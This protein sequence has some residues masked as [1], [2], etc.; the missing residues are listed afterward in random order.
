MALEKRLEAVSPQ[1]L[2]SD[3]TTSGRVSV[4]D[5]SLFKVKQQIILNSSSQ[6]STH[7]EVKRILDINTMILGPKSTNIKEYT[8]LSDFTVA[9]GAYIIANEQLRPSIPYEEYSR[10]TYDE[11]PTVANRSV[12]VDKMGDYYEV[13]NPLP[14]QLSDGSINIGVVEA[15][16]EVQ[17]THLDDW[18]E[19]GRIHDSTRIGDGED[20]LQ[21]SEFGEAYVTQGYSSLLPMLSAIPWVQRSNYDEV[22]PTFNG[23]EVTLSYRERGTEIGQAVLTF[24]LQTGIWN[25][26]SESYAVDSDGEQLLDDDGEVILLS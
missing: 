20:Q 26:T 9:D 12:L 24:N 14:V 18:P 1:L 7:L 4:Q 21:I 6:D 3:G 16:V 17:I 13:H 15:N 25:F 10:A 2:Q 23:D 22:V 5:A 11:E 8:D 19:Q